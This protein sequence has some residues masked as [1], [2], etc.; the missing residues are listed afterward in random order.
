[1]L[2]APIIN[3]T[4]LVNTPKLLGPEKRGIELRAWVEKYILG[5]GEAE[6]EEVAED[7]DMVEAVRMQMGE[8]TIK[9]RME[10]DGKED[11]EKTEKTAKK[12]E[13]GPR[14]NKPTDTLPEVQ[15]RMP[16][17]KYGEGTKEVGYIDATW[18]DEFHYLSEI[19]QLSFC[20]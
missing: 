17:E 11:D 3:G 16:G 8:V 7:K 20:N 4:G 18:G 15:L 12:N 9:D 14:P 2:S 1:M 10:V 5:G 13:D 19:E 6:T